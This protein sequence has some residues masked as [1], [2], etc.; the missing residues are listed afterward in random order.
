MSLIRHRDPFFNNWLEPFDSMYNYDANKFFR[1][2]DEHMREMH[3]RMLMHMPRPMFE[4]PAFPA[5]FGADWS[6]KWDEWFE[7]MHNEMQ[8]HMPKVSDDGKSVSLSVNLPEYV[9]PKKVK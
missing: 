7:R 6:S 2:I 9:D 1:H 8:M 3:N 4:W 5:S